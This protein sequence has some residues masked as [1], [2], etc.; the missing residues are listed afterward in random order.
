[1]TILI[2]LVERAGEVVTKREL[3]ARVW[4][5]TLVHEANLRMHIAALRKVLGDGEGGMRAISN[6]T[7]R[8]YCFIAPVRRVELNAPE[9]AASSAESRHSSPAILTRI[10]GRARAIETIVLQVPLRRCVTVVGPGG[11]GK[12]TVAVAVAERLR[13]VY[14]DGAWFV[15]F[16]TLTDPQL[17]PVT[18]AAELGLS[19]DTGDPLPGLLAFLRDRRLLLVLDNCEHVVEAVA[20]L[21]ERLLRDARNVNILA[22]SRETLRIEGEWVHRLAPLGLPPEDSSLTAAQALAFPAVQLFVECASA[23]LDGFEMDDADTAIVSAICRRL[24]GLPLAIELAAMRID[25]FGLH[26][27]ASALNEQ[28]LL[29]ST[30]LRTAQPRQQSLLRTLQWSYELLSPVE[31]RVLRR[32][33]IFQRDFTLDAAVEVANGDGI[34]PEEVYASVL[35]LFAKSLITTDVSD[36]APQHHY[37]LLHVTR[38][39]ARQILQNSGEAKGMAARLP[40]YLCRLLTKAESHWDGLSRPAWLTAYGRAIDDVRA[41]LDWAFSPD[42]DA[43]VGVALTALALPLGFQLSLIDEFRGRVERALLHCG[44]VTPPQTLAEMRLNIALANLLHNTSGPVPGRT[45]AIGRA[46]EL[47][48]Q[49]ERPTFKIEP[50][51]GLAAIHL[52]TGEYAAALEVATEAGELAELSRDHMAHLATDRLLAQVSHFVGDHA[53]AARL[54]QSLLADS[55]PRLPLAYNAMPVDRHVAMRIVLA[56]VAWIQ[57]QP[58]RAG[59]LVEEALER[60][61]ADN[62][63]SLCPTLA[64]AAIPIALWTGDDEA[65]GTLTRTL[66]DQAAR[67]T[68]AYWQSWA[69]NYRRLLD[70]RAS[71][72]G[73]PVPLVGTLQVDTFPTFSI[74]LLTP[75]SAMRAERGAAGWCQPEI[76]RVQGEW[77]LAEGTPGSAETA[78]SM[79]RQA[80]EIARKQGALSWELRAVASLARLWERNGR[81]KVGVDALAEVL[82]RFR[83]GHATAD[84]REAASF[85]KR[86][87]GNAGGGATKGQTIMRPAAGDARGRSNAKNRDR[88]G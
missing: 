76:R 34:E 5:E 28:F 8:G 56:R 84:L 80:I 14:D 51:I 10:V 41:G 42:G 32:L 43:A 3:L 35:T 81:Q 54:A 64:F 62:A 88:S 40:D 45:G 39:F 25:L 73:E 15:D 12:T 72:R 70:Q 27:L 24:D 33:S 60:A 37:H 82:S 67:F 86:S 18:L 50:L 69:V 59:E 23:S 65:A 66:G 38:A 46:I 2:A 77:L 16:A 75:A 17:V 55:V 6:V 47:S 21:A 79:F 58:E 22:T 20:I 44:R 1:M 9:P 68:L 71:G 63:F 7:G 19:L 30:G 49:L 85:L 53:R 48:R 57:G 11:M 83:E 13:P 26:G 61:K 36:E 52:G 78:E 74:H 29:A 4:P 31:Q 87:D